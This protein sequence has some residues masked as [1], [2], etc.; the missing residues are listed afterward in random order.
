LAPGN[1][2]GGAFLSAAFAEDRRRTLPV[3]AELAPESARRG[4]EAVDAVLSRRD[5]VVAV[6]GAPPGLGVALRKVWRFALLR[7]VC[8]VCGRRARPA[9]ALADARGVTF[10]AVERILELLG[11]ARRVPLAGTALLLPSVRAAVGVRTLSSCFG[12]GEAGGVRATGARLERTERRLAVGVRAPVEAAR[13]SDAPELEAMRRTRASALIFAADGAA[14]LA[15][16]EVVR[17][18]GVGAV[19]VG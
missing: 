8:D 17:I 1:G 18:A 4:N 9:D 12:A 15:V 13:L 3:D 10:A 11:V 19:A 6:A 14:L 7:L 5:R 16:L 2:D